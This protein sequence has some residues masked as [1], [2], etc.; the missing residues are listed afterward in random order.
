[1]VAR[2]SIKQRDSRIAAHTLHSVLIE[3]GG[4]TYNEEAESER[5]WG[6]FAADLGFGLEG[7][8]KEYRKRRRGRGNGGNDTDTMTTKG[9]Q[10]V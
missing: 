5:K 2:S 9:A 4:P 6:D 3:D 7:L 8:T 1:M 10:S